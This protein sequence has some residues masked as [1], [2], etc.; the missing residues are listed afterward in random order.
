MTG[1]PTPH[2]VR[3]GGRDP[4]PDRGGA[5][6]AAAAG[7]PPRRM[8]KYLLMRMCDSFRMPIGRLQ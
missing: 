7:D 3:I 5:P 6:V 2:C 4:G 8:S 1:A